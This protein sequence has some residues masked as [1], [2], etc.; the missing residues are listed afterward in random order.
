MKKTN[1]ME[2]SVPECIIVFCTAVKKY[3]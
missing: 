1:F 3:V 2:N